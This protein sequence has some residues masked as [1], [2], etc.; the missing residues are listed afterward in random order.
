MLNRIN[1]FFHIPMWLFILLLFVVI[2]RIPNFFEP[3]SY[4]DETIYLTLGQGVRQGLTL[5]KNLHD[6]KPPLLYLTAAVA[7][8]LFYFKT[9]LLG[10]SLFGTILFFRFSEKLFPKIKLFPIVSTIIYTVLTT[11][12]FLEGNIAN[13]ENFM[14]VTTIAAF[15]MILFGS[16]SLRNIFVSGVLLSLSSMYKIPAVFDAGAVFLFW[17]ITMKFDKSSII[18]LLSKTA[19][20]LAGIFSPIILSFIY[21]WVKGA[22]GEYLI[23]AYLQNF[24]YLSSWRPS[25]QQ[26]PFFIRNAPLFIRFAAVLAINV[27]LFLLR[28]KVDKK[29]LFVVSW[30][31]FSIFGIT[32]SERP[33]PHY[34]LQASAPVAIL[35]SLLF[36]SASMLQVYAVIPLA[37]FF[38][39]PLYYRFWHYRSVNYYS[40]FVNMATGT[41]SKDDYLNTFGGRTKTNYEI[42]KIVNRLTNKTDKIFVWEDSAQI[43]ALSQKL[44]PI[45][46]IAGYHINDFSSMENI[47]K[48]FNSS[49]PKVIVVFRSSESSPALS[50]FIRGNYLLFRKNEDYQIWRFGGEYSRY[51]LP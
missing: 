25:S 6:N 30:L 41:I 23:A 49:P 44:P 39:I 10:W 13:A 35:T 22:F 1:K 17:I 50:N 3:Y 34:L 15:Y 40:N 36:T 26:D 47:V 38:F 43:Y 8:N 27:F 16:G 4:G 45:K 7:G 12:P 14:I 24:G 51:I 33:Y 37:A 2:F 31:T 21:Y 29:F 9:I 19:V 46:Y 5:Y 28:K 18:R 11:L 32:L 48:T 20:L 42:A